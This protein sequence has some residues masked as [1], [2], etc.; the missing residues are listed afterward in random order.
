[1]NGWRLMHPPSFFHSTHIDGIQCSMA[2]LFLTI[3]STISTT[4]KWSV[5]I[6]HQPNDIDKRAHCTLSLIVHCKID[7]KWKK[8]LK[9]VSLSFFSLV[10]VH[11]SDNCANVLY[12]ST[13]ILL[14]FDD[15]HQVR[16]AFN[17]LSTAVKIECIRHWHL[18]TSFDWKT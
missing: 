11:P 6:V 13:V 8:S 4:P 17:D 10:S 7:G 9:C 3:L 18:V 5:K 14:S 12:V 16:L 15:F 2:Y 1:M